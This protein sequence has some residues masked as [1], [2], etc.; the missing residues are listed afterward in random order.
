MNPAQQTRPPELTPEVLYTVRSLL[1]LQRLQYN[2]S[3]RVN[4][5]SGMQVY[6]PISS[7]WLLVELALDLLGVPKTYLPVATDGGRDQEKWEEGVHFDRGE[8]LL[9]WEEQVGRQGDIEGYIKSVLGV[10]GIPPP[11]SEEEQA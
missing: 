8:H 5:V 2:W 7:D 9:L 4:S 1:R 11:M 3:Q 10:E 6:D